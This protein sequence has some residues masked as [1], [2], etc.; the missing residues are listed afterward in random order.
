MIYCLNPECSQPKNP[1]QAKV[2]QTCGRSLLLH[3][4][5]LSL[6]KL[7]QGGFGTTFLAVDLSL[8]GKPPC[9]IK[10]LRPATNIPHVF[11]MAKELFEREAE[12]LGKIGNHPQIPRLLDYFA[13]NQNFYLVQEFVRG[14]NL[15]QEVKQNGPFSE[16]GIKQFLQELLPMV[17]Y[18]HSQEVIHRDIKPSNLIR[19]EQDKK[20]VLIDF[21]AVKNQ[22]N[23]E[24]SG[25]SG[26]TALTS[27]AVG[28]P[29]FAPP[30]QMAM[31]P[32]YAS[33]I[34]AI[35]VTCLY[36]LTAKAPK[37]MGYNPNTGE[38]LWEKYV[39]VSDHFKNV[40]SKMLE[41]SVRHR[42][43]SA[44]DVLRAL[45]LE[46]Y[47][48]S[49]TDSMTT[50]PK[51]NKLRQ[52]NSLNSGLLSP[53]PHKNAKK[54]NLSATEKLARQIRAKKLRQGGQTTMDFNSSG[55]LT[56][57]RATRKNL[58]TDSQEKTL[59]NRLDADNV[60][61]F[62]AKGRR[63]FA[64][65]NLNNL[66]LKQANLTKAS[67]HQSD[68]IAINLEKANLS[69]ADLGRSNLSKSCLV[70][71]NL[72]RAYLSYANLQGADL[73]GADLQFASL[74]HANLK[75]ANLCGANLTNAKVTE[76]QINQAKT[77]WR[78]ILPSGK[79]GLFGN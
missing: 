62:Y 11:K 70:N 76:E 8:P 35:G 49:L 73:R 77:N 72:E 59:L 9:V 52:D 30:E 13:Y 21:G 69:G 46:P 60:L 17:E 50:L 27:F 68:L 10:Q 32:V 39:D 2:C 66:N 38:T 53:N 71:A 5:Y 23:P 3:K 37:D 24:L 29:G 67:F 25:V 34:Y 47:F 28:T 33:D 12:T 74:S 16:A 42:Y 31:R 19:R 43:Q 4:R 78:T 75:G 48:E 61:S 55:M 56:G 15:Q 54:T 20:L 79:R 26:D 36:L 51:F 18:V 22:I 58:G 45:D 1:R 14:H 63:D 57:T 40:L 7:G 65:K 6:K 64:Q 41:I 44:Q